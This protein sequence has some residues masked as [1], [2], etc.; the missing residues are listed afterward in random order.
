MAPG[1]K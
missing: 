1:D